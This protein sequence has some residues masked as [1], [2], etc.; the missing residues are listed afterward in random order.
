MLE[1][2]LLKTITE[3]NLIQ[4]GDNIVIGVSG[5]P[6]SMALL[7]MLINLRKENKIDAKLIVAHINHGIREE[8]EEETKYV[9]DFCD[10][11]SI[12]CYIKREKVEE[13]AKEQ[14]VGTEEAGRKLR[15]SFFD[16]V[17]NKENANKIATA[18]NANDN[19][20]TVLM[21]IM[22][23]SGTSGLKGI[24][25]KRDDKFIRPLLKI[26]RKEI[27][28]YCEDNKLNPKIDRTN[29]ENIYT[30][31][32][33]RNE[34]IPSI[35][36]EFNPNIV[37]SLNRLSELLNEEDEYIQKV[38]ENKYKDVLIE[39]HL[40]NN[41]LEGKE[42]IILDLK[43]F[44]KEEKVIK[45]RLIRYTINKATGSMQNIEK[46]HVS[47]IVK[48]CE[49]NIGNKFLVPNKRIKVFVGKGKIFFIK[50]V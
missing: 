36:K 20:E 13:L 9:K 8:A 28:T 34:L 45:N 10:S 26:T 42:Q 17:A 40:G 50:E 23:G 3:Y 7:N 2:K 12:P 22:R 32:K 25:I 35:E 15:Y 33:I 39:E 48:L 46:V 21:N 47:D 1:E 49:N 4:K 5:G 14:K 29:L 24:E 31:N 18:H 37:T 30:R 11:N 16:E 6:D 19:A 44:N 38:V 41:K 27:E 43:K